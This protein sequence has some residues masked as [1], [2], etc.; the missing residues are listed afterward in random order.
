MS[1]P[2]LEDR[3]PHRPPRRARGRIGHCSKSAGTG[4]GGRRSH[5][6]LCAHLRERVTVEAA[7]DSLLRP[8]ATR[9]A[10]AP[11]ADPRGPA[12]APE[13]SRPERLLGRELPWR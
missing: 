12:V 10:A 13:N 6:S 5:T 11:R 2:S 9:H 4:G 7:C 8:L 1:P 3:I